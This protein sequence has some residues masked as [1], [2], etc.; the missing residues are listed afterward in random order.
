AMQR[1]AED[2]QIERQ[3]AP[4]RT[5]ADAV[6]ERRPRAPKHPQARQRHVAPERVRD[7]IDRVAELD[8][9][10]NAMK[11]AERCAPGLEERLRC[12]HEDAHRENTALYGHR[13][14]LNN[15]ERWPQKNTE[16]GSR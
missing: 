7:E 3:L 11:F 8:E 15:P 12:D 2:E 10:A 5:D 1:R 13:N 14:T 9:R 16:P 4:G 6:H